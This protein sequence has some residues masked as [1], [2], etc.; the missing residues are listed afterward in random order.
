VRRPLA[1]SIVLGLAVVGSQVA[2][3]LA[4]RLAR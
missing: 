4:Y 1:W 3:G 2:H